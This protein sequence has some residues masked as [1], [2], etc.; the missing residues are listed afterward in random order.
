LNPRLERSQRLENLRLFDLKSHSAIIHTTYRN[1]ARRGDL[2]L[3]KLENGVWL[4]GAS[5]YVVC[6]SL[7]C[8]LLAGCA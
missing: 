3:G 7:F 1:R 8:R 4:N 5:L 6:I 2:V